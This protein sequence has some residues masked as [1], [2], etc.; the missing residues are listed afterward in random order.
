MFPLPET[1]SITYRKIPAGK[2][3]AEVIFKNRNTWFLVLN[4]FSVR[5]I[6]HSLA[7]TI[8]PQKSVFI[9]C[10]R[11]T[12]FSRIVTTSSTVTRRPVFFKEIGGIS[13]HS[14][15]MTIGA[16]FTVYKEIIKKYKFPGKRM[17]IRCYIFTKKNKVAISVSLR[18]IA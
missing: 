16:Y 8:I 10:Y 5:P 6:A 4:K 12:P 2:T 3:G 14:P 7:L 17:L 9:I 1:D 11:H 18:Q 13:S 15:V